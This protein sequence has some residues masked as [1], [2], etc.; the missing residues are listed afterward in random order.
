VTV[1]R[2]AFLRR[3]SLLLLA[4]SVYGCLRLAL[5]ADDKSVLALLLLALRAFVLSALMAALARLIVISLLCCSLLLSALLG[6]VPLPLT[7]LA[8]GSSRHP[9]LFTDHGISPS[10]GILPAAY[11]VWLFLPFSSA[12]CT[13][14]PQAVPI[15]CRFCLYIAIPLTVSASFA[16]SFF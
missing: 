8:V 16:V 12:I 15:I 9:P 13:R 2:F 5:L 1:L 11:W 14:Y 7:I 4:L 3:S 6:P 10:D